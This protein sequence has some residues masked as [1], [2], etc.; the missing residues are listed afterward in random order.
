MTIEAMLSQTSKVKTGK[1]VETDDSNSEDEKDLCFICTE[2]MIISSVA[3]C[4]HRTCHLCALRLRALY[5]TRQCTYCKTEQSTVIFTKD[6][7]KSFMDYDTEHMLA[8]KALDARFETKQI[9]KEAVRILQY[10]CPIPGCL[11]VCDQGWSELKVHIKKSHDLL[12]CD[13]CTRHKKVFAHEHILYTLDQLDKHHKQG[14]KLV[15]QDEAGFFGHPEC[16]FCRMRF[17]GD[18]ELFEHCRDKHEQCHICVRRGARHEYYANYDRLEDHF[19]R[20]HFLCLGSQCLEKKFVVFESAIDLKAHEV[21]V[22][23]ASIGNLQRAKKAEARRIDINFEYADHSRRHIADQSQG[24]ERHM[25][26]RTIA[27]LSTSE[28]PSSRRDAIG[29]SSERIVPG[30]PTKK[31]NQ[32]QLFQKPK[33]FGNLSTSHT[34]VDHETLARHSTFLEKLRQLFK[35]DEK[36]GK[37]RALT[38]S[39]RNSEI[40][41]SEYLDGILVLCDR[42]IQKASTVIEGVEALMDNADK[43]WEISKAWKDRENELLNFPALAATNSKKA[44][45]PSSR[46]LVIKGST[47]Q[48][49]SGK[50][51]AAKSDVIPTRGINSAKQHKTAWAGTSNSGS[52]SGNNSIGTSKTASLPDRGKS[53]PQKVNANEFP[54]LPTAAPKHPIVVNMRRTKALH[55]NAWISATDTDKSETIESAIKQKKGKKAK[56]VLFR[57]GL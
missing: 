21:E 33:G 45:A 36:V 48:A 2:P 4:D 13:L 37:F 5:G 6:T 10:N 43:I 31:K 26:N 56:Q 8:D 40:A 17:Y 24:S 32:Q 16:Q 12:L 3:A 41:I 52:A 11:E 51:K 22:H 54:T 29:T 15:E 25:A 20:K 47:K 38:T 44:A 50:A 9:Y 7:E 23:G 57:V 30:A 42:N 55:T 39:Y 1:V 34:S 28:E 14:S 18:D 35:S 53:I 19:R 27:N 46:V 49:A